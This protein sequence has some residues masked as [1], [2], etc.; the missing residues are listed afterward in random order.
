MR[1][2][3]EKPV[4]MP[5]TSVVLSSYRGGI[6]RWKGS[7][8]LSSALLCLL[9]IW[10]SPKRTMSR[11]PKKMATAE[12]VFDF[13][14]PLHDEDGITLAASN[15][16]VVSRVSQNNIEL[17]T[18]LFPEDAHLAPR[19]LERAR[20]AL[21]K[22]EHLLGPYPYRRLAIVENSFKVGQAQPTYILLEPGDFQRE[23]FDRTLDHEIV[24]QWFGCAVSPDYDQGNW[25]E[26][27]ATYFSNHLLQEE[28]GLGWQCRRRILSG[29]PNPH[30]GA[31]GISPAQIHR[32]L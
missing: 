10:L 6:L 4:I 25:C 20:H 11:A 29:F 21:A 27:M 7:A 23:D 17:L 24:H 15:R 16:W 9:D 13:P 32:A 8:G 1:Q 31:S 28:T 26:G 2:V 14:Y 5:W 18:Y 19:Y 30:R 3:W 22:Y 12:F